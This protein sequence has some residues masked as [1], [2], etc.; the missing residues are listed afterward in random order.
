MLRRCETPPSPPALDLVGIENC[1]QLFS[2]LLS[3]RT[4]KIVTNST[5]IISAVS[6]AF[7]WVVNASRNEKSCLQFLIPT[8]VFH[9]LL[10][11]T[12]ITHVKKKI[13]W[14]VG[15]VENLEE[16]PVDQSLKKTSTIFNTLRI[17]ILHNNNAERLLSNR[18]KKIV[19]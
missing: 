11:P 18:E 9:M 15:L 17:L 1:K 4:Q 13:Q 7:F 10:T 5:D 2:P 14:K 8:A 16:F 12:H 6:V 3:C 19:Q